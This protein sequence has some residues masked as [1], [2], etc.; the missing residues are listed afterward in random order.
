MAALTITPGVLK[1]ASAFPDPPFEVEPETGFDAEL[2]QK[3]C[4]ALGLTWQLV[5]YAGQDFDGIFDG[6]GRDYDAVIS[7]TT[8]TPARQKVALFSTPY[9]VFNQGVAVSTARHPGIRSVEGLK[10]LTVGIQRGNTSDN[11]ARKLLAEGIIAGIRYYPYAAIRTALNDLAGGAIGAVIKLHPVLTELV[12]GHAGL[13][14]VCDVPTHEE[15]AIAVA[16]GNSALRD[17]IDAEQAKL[18]ADPWFAMTKAKWF[19]PAKGTAT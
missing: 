16:S 12:K 7:G 3:I 13:S 17:A 18:M 10:G 9:L 2:M 6:L 4:A 14:V 11:V 5:K 8:I 19:G 1:V 15:I